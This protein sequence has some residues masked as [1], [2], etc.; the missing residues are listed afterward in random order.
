M[1]LSRDGTLSVVAEDASLGDIIAKVREIKPFVFEQLGPGFADTPISGRFVGPARLVVEQLMHDENHLIYVNVRN[2]DVERLVVLGPRGLRSNDASPVA[3]SLPLETQS[4]SARDA[5]AASHPID[6]S[7]TS[8]DLRAVA[9]PL[10][11]D[12]GDEAAGRRSLQG[13]FSGRSVGVRSRR[14]A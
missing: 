13:A 4:A 8:G 10:G 5:A 3:T 1:E 12:D 6:L 7:S 9:G 14:G 11:L 2:R